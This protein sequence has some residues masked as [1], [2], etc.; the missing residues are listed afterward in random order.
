MDRSFGE[1]AGAKRGSPRSTNVSQ[2]CRLL[3]TNANTT[4]ASSRN[5]VL[6][7]R[8]P[9]P[10][11]TGPQ[12]RLFRGGSSSSKRTDLG[13]SPAAGGGFVGQAGA[14]R[15]QDVRNGVPCRRRATLDATCQQRQLQFVSGGTSGIGDSRV[16]GRPPRGQTGFVLQR[17]RMEGASETF[18]CAFHL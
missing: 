11:M 13:D 10:W 17:G 7:G 14:A 15:W 12:A 1:P 5:A 6:R 9:G 2:N 4:T 18:G 3:R 8:K 16:Q